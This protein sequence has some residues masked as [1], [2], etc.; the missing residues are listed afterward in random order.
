MLTER[1][2]VFKVGLFVQTGSD[3]AS[4]EG[5][6]CDTQRATAGQSPTSSWSSS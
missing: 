6:V 4:I 5:A 3:L 1:T 2:K